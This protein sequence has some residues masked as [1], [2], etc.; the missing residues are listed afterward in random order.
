MQ[1]EA[2]PL[3]PDFIIPPWLAAALGFVICW[4]LLGLVALTNQSFP[5]DSRDFARV[6]FDHPHWFAY[7]YASDLPVEPTIL[8]TAA[9]GMLW[10]GFVRPVWS[11]RLFFSA[12][13]I[14]TSTVFLGGIEHT[15]NWFHHLYGSTRTTASMVAYTTLFM[16]ARAANRRI[17]AAFALLFIFWGCAEPLIW[18]LSTPIAVAGGALLAAAIF[19]FGKFLA[20]LAGV[21]PFANVDITD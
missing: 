4:I 15:A 17:P 19:C 20:Q 1:R 16:N 13:L 8:A 7:F 10:V 6:L 9:V 2:E 11:E 5:Y 21:N 14:L 12:A 3:E 18:Q